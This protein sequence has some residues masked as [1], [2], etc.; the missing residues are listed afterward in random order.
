MPERARRSRLGVGTCPP[1]VP[2]CAK[3]ASSIKIIRTLGAPLGGLTRAIL[4]GLESLYVVPMTP[5]NSGV[6]C[7]RTYSPCTFDGVVCLQE[8]RRQ[9]GKAA[10]AKAMKPRFFMESPNV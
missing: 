7:G 4:S 8:T 1:K 5:L 6:G 9:A 3:P 2:H 10:S